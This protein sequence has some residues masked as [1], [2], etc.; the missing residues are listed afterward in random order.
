MLR[1]HS[2]DVG[3]SARERLSIAH[4]VDGPRHRLAL[5]GV[6]DLSTAAVFERTLGQATSHGGELIVDLEG[7]SFIDSSGLRALLGCAERCEAAGCV[8]AFARPSEP[9]KRLFELSG[10]TA[11][12]PLVEAGLNAEALKRQRQGG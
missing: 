12:L 10:V 2:P 6:L 4:T 11:R 7:V 5:D 8:L 9:A 1:R 3:A